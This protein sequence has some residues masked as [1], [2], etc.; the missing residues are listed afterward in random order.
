MTTLRW[1]VLST[2]NIGQ[3]A[4]IPAILKSDNGRLVAIASRNLDRAQAFAAPFDQA[5]G[6]PPIRVYASYE[7]LLA[8]PEVDAIYNPLPNSLHK[9]WSIRAMQAGKHVLCEKPL[10]SNL[11]EVDE[12]IAVAESTG[13]L[14]MEAFMYR[15]HPRTQDALER[16]IRGDIGAL[17][18]IRSAFTFPLSQNSNIRLNA[19]LA[20]GSLMDVGCYCVNIIRTALA[21]LGV[22]EPVAVAAFANFGE[23]TGVEESMSAILRF[24]FPDG[25]AGPITAHFDSSLRTDG[26]QFY[27]FAGSGGTIRVDDAFNAGRFDNLRLQVMKGGKVVTEERYDGSDQYQLMVQAFAESVL[28]GTPLAYPMQESRGNMAV[29]DALLHSAR[30]GQVVP[31]KL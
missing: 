10:G 23:E 1:G 13:M 20:G 2:A 19:E 5:Q 25:T 3:K 4:V 12:M 15:F 6:G 22:G 7:V 9:E 28:H 21:S 14:L 30:T 16:L 11:A 24:E 17:Q 8:D 26:R 29:I 18:T 31:V 27:E